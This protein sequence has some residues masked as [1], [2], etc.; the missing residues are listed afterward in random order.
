MT[1]FFRYF[2]NFF[3]VGIITGSLMMRKLKVQ[4]AAKTA[5]K[6]CVIISM[7]TAFNSFTF[8]I[9]GCSNTNVAGVMVPYHNR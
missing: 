2:F 9:P 1:G 6:I 4:V 3:L 8:L 7:L 5:A